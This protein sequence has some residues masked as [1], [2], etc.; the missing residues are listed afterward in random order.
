MSTIEKMICDNCKTESKDI[1]GDP[2]WISFNWVSKNGFVVSVS[3]GRKA[4]GNHY[5]KS[6]KEAKSNVDFCSVECMLKWMGI[7]PAC[8]EPKGFIIINYGPK[9]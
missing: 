6:Y 8:N 4:G 5:E 3:A 7:M 2:D 1:C 9:L